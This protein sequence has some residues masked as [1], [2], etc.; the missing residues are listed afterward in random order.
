[1]TFED[2]GKLM[3]QIKVNYPYYY[4]EMDKGMQMVAVKLFK[5]LLDD[6]PYADC[7]MALLQYMSEPHQF[8]PTAGQ[9]RDLAIKIRCPWGSSQIKNMLPVV[10]KY[11]N[12]I[13]AGHE[14]QI[15]TIGVTGD[16]GGVYDDKG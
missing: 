7:E 9:I 6:L 1:M 12:T 5:T 4:R 15:G 14:K 3:A 11:N 13:T 10:Q 2:A 8:P 16:T